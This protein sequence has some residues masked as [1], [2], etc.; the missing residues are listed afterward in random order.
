MSPRLNITHCCVLQ[1]EEAD[2]L[3]SEEEVWYV[4]SEMAQVNLVS[5]HRFSAHVYVACVRAV[6]QHCL[7]SMHCLQNLG[8]RRICLFGSQNACSLVSTHDLALAAGSTFSTC[9][10]SL[11]S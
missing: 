8:P 4:L 7:V 6:T 2:E 10:W 3:L 5:E 9:E 11:A 1:L